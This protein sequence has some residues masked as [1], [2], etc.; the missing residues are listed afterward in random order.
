MAR[1]CFT[2]SPAGN[3]TGESVICNGQN[4]LYTIDPLYDADTYIWN[5]TGTGVTINVMGSA[6]YLNFS[7]SATNGTLTVFGSNSCG[8]GAV[9]NSFNITILPS[10]APTVTIS[11]IGQTEFCDGDSATL[12][13]S[14]MPPISNF[15]WQKNGVDLVG[16]TSSVLKV[17]DSGIYSVKVVGGNGCQ[18]TAIASIVVNQLPVPVITSIWSALFSNYTTG[19]QWYLNNTII[20]GATNQQYTATSVGNYSVLVTDGNNCQN[21]SAPFFYNSISESS[22]QRFKIAPNPTTGIVTLEHNLNEN[23]SLT[24][25]DI[26]G[27]TIYQSILQKAEKTTQLDFSNLAKGIYFICVV[28]EKVNAVQKIVLQ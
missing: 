17:F 12:Q 3:I 22:D 23:V 13:A 18:Q 24:V 16:E 7:A 11:V 8:N 15:Q 9:S 26:Y 14:V 21:F 2:P 19:N 20:P 28:G 4:A 5:Y 1:Y 10:N 27:K 25:A 6:A